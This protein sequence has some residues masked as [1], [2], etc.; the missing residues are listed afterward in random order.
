MK[1]SD[2]A[3]HIGLTSFFSVLLLTSIVIAGSASNVN[4]QSNL[5]WVRGG[6]S[7]PSTAVIGGGDNDGTTLYI[8]RTAHSGTT[9]PGKVVGTK[10]NYNW[11]TTEYTSGTFDVLVG[12][13][14]YW[15]DDL[16]T[17]TALPAAIGSGEIYYICSAQTSN[18]T[19]PGRIQNGKCNYSYGGRGYSTNDFEVLNGRASGA[20]SAVTVSL[21]DAASLGDAANVRAALKAGQA[22]NQK[23]T[24]G[25]TA[26]M[27]A[28]TKGNSEVLRILLNEGAT[29]DVRDNEGFTA[30]GYA[31][32]AGDLQS[33][34]QL[35]RA[36]ANL[37]TRTDSGN[38]PLYFAAASGDIETVRAITSDSSFPGFESSRSGFPLH[39]AAAYG[40]VNVIEMLINDEEVDV[41]QMDASG[42][43]ALMVAGRNNKPAA[44]TALLRADADTSIK[45]SNNNDVFSLSAYYNATDSMGVLLNTEKFS[46]R[47]PV[48]EGAMRMVARDSKIPAL[49][50]LLQRGVD[51]NAVVRNV[52]TTALMLASFEGHDGVVKVL[53]TS[54]ANVNAAN[55]KGETA[56]ILAA[57][58]GKRDVVKLLIKA[59]ADVLATDNNGKTAAQYAAQNGHSDTRKDL[60]KA[61]GN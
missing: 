6:G 38:T 27:L 54:R 13:G 15:T 30:L 46:V 40:R 12:T 4:G 20:D 47:S 52:G 26:L 11:G 8:C 56:L 3:R 16:N 51:P 42:Q 35:L 39:G 7:I 31:A 22:I 59:G 28:A 33:V 55:Q 1:I 61:G 48:V 58:A 24:K 32:F 2:L 9:V 57:S 14:E 21:L 60:E 45:T 36:G 23:N 25:Q 43:T 49:T 17:R 29:V 5:R 44:V 10:C 34:R 19:H 50:Y 18:G 41:D 37:S 53:L